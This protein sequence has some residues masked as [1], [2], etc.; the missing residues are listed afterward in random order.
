MALALFVPCVFIVR[1][2]PFTRISTTKSWFVGVSTSVFLLKLRRS[3]IVSINGN[4]C[5]L[6]C[7]S[8]YLNTFYARYYGLS[9]YSFSPS[10]DLIPAVICFPFVLL[11]IFSWSDSPI[12]HTS[13]YQHLFCF[14]LLKNWIQ[15]FEGILF[16]SVTC[17][18]CWCYPVS[19]FANCVSFTICA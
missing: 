1:S 2:N 9:N 10:Y 17:C 8:T 13:F 6:R 15:H 7:T 5:S 4:V 16:A 18:F 12:K 19:A 14:V 11:K 3:R